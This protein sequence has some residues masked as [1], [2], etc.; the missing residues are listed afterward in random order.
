[1]TTEKVGKQHIG[2]SLCISQSIAREFSEKAKT[3]TK[4]LID[5]ELKVILVHSSTEPHALY[6]SCTLS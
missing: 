2:Y 5:L 6:L 4:R 1:M 3:T